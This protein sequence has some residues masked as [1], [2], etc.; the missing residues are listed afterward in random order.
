[1]EDAR[2]PLENR[3]SDPVELTRRWVETWLRA[4]PELERIERAEL[5]KFDRGRAI[6]LLC[7][8][9]D[10]TM[11]PRAPLPTSGLVEF[12]RWLRLLARHEP[13]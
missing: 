13:S 5:Q 1:M 12:Q 9:A 4:G 11:P 7:Y 3:P 10:Y 2:S 6:A 8:D